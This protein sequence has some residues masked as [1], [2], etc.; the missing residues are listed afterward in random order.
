M[1][2]PDSLA[3]APEQTPGGT[4]QLGFSRFLAAI[5]RPGCHETHGF[6]EEPGECRCHYGW[7]GPFCD[8]C[9]LFPGCVHGSCTEPWKCDCDTGWGGLLCDKEVIACLSEPCSHGGSCREL[10]DGF[11]C[12]CPPQWMGKTCQIGESCG[13]LQGSAFLPPSFPA[14]HGSPLPWPS[15]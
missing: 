11:A 7:T 14:P 15:V 5:C 8:R 12:I 10:A 13:G 2:Q 9:I 1:Q 6:C 3:A 4:L